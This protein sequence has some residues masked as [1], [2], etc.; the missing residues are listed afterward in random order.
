MKI[1]GR[2]LC[3]AI[4]YEAEVDPKQSYI[5]NCTDCQILAGSAF[6][7][8]VTVPETDFKLLSGKLKRFDKTSE[9]GE[10]LPMLFCPDCGSSLYSIYVV[11]GA[12][13]FNIRV[14]TA[15]QHAELPPKS[16]YWTRSAQQWLPEVNRI[17]AN[18]TE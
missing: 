8:S 17:E 10:L 4:T 1:D 9:H 3:G 15:R 13:Y 12:R 16:Q 18:E 5:C 2:C 7:W 6:R 11:D 14:P